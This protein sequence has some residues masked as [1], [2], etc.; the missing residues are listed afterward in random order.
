MKEFKGTKGPWYGKDVVICNQDYARLQLGFLN[1]SS[2]ERRSV[3]MANALLI[4]A[5]P[6]LLEALQEVLYE[7]STAREVHDGTIRQADAAIAKAL[8]ETK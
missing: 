5:A 8:G 2:E 4:A 6:D 1:T 7:L 3:G